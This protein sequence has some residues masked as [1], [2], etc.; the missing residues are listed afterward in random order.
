MIFEW[1]QQPWKE[2]TRLQERF[3]HAIL[4]QSGEGLGEFEFARACAQS[5]LCEGP[6][7]GERPC[8]SCRAC[9]WFSLGNHPDF[10]LIVPESMAPEP[11]EEGVEPAKKKSEQIRIE[12]VRELGDFTGSTPSSRG[13]GAM[14]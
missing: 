14:L 5:L 6:R 8:G 7:P 13:S 12:Q 9:G 11:R 2:W 1:Q 10:R 4:I 3:P